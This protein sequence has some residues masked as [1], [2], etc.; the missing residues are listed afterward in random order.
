MSPRLN[1]SR[2]QI[3]VQTV[4][5][6]AMAAMGL[7]Y[8][9]LLSPLRTIDELVVVASICLTGLMFAGESLRGNR[10]AGNRQ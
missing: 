5:A 4:V 6:C 1:V 9:E 10:S 3:V 7:A 8:A 2:R